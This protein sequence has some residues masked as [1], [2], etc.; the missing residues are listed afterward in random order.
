MRQ[1]LTSDL[2]V[3]AL[4]GLFSL[5]VFVVALAVLSATLPDGLGDRQLVGLVFGYLLFV[6]VYAVA[7][8]I[9][10]GIEAREEV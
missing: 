1:R 8:F 9:Y 7:W 4:S 10:T 6:G 3:Y 5:V 2:G